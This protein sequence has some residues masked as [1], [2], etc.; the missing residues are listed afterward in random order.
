MEV[1]ERLLLECMF[2]ERRRRVLSSLSSFSFRVRFRP[3]RVSQLLRGRTLLLLLL[4]KLLLSAGCCTV[5]VGRCVVEGFVR[6]SRRFGAGIVS[7]CFRV[8]LFGCC[9]ILKYLGGFSKMWEG[10]GREH[11]WDLSLW[12]VVLCGSTAVVGGEIGLL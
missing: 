6:R 10:G 9:W 4:L 2:R 11:G 7:V 8:L 3:L 1:L 5:C 12:A